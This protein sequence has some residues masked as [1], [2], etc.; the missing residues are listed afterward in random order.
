[1]KR[2]ILAS[3]TVGLA[4]LM[5]FGCGNVFDSATGTQNNSAP[6]FNGP[7]GGSPAV[8]RIFALDAQ[9]DLLFFMSDNPLVIQGKTTPTGLP[10]GERLI[11]IDFRPS[12]GILYGISNTGKVF[13]LD[14]VTAQAFQV[15]VGP[16]P[17]QVAADIDFNPTVDRIREVA[18][19]QNV[20]VNPNT[21]LLVP[22]GDAAL[23]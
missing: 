7:A 1:L 4:A 6:P 12:T 11:S 19:S 13:Y 18:G 20:R 16:V 10:V 22:P 5:T 14:K 23:K 17:A 2:T 3:V 21:G 8:V 9:G 15:G